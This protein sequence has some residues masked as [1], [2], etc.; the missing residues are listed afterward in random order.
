MPG[1]GETRAGDT[2]SF[3]AVIDGPGGTLPDD[4]RAL[5]DRGDIAQVPYV[6]G[7][8]H[9]EGTT[10]VWRAASITTEQEYLADLEQRFGDAA[11]EVA[12]L[13]PASDFGGSYDDARARVVGDASLVCGTHDTAR[14]AARAG[15]DVFMYDFEFPWSL[16]PTVLKAGHAAEISHAF[17]VPYLPVPDPESEALA[18]DMNTYWARFAATGD[19]SFPGAPQDWPRFDPNADER[20]HITP[21]WAVLRDFRAAECAF[22]RA[23]NDAE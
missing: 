15:L 3:A 8:N 12:A 22:W 4:L 2:W 23:Y 21:Q 6:L 9:D 19:P 11:A 17:G 14:R 5:F 20:L 1:A 16:L 13:Y 18:Q 10:F 7:S